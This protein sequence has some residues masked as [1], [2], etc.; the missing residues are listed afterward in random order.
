MS[1]IRVAARYAKAL[2]LEATKDGRLEKL[3]EDIDDF[4]K[5]C[6]NSRPLM[7][8]LSNPIIAPERKAVV[9]EEMFHGKLGDKLINAFKVICKK[10]REPYLYAIAQSVVH[11][12][13]R[14]KDIQEA[15]VIT[16][17]EISPRIKA[18]VIRIVTESTNKRVSLKESVDKNIIGGYILKIG[19]KRLDNS[20]KSQLNK[21]KNSF[22]NN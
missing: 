19:D 4:I 11:E 18:E 8:F 10:N 14:L 2:V 1:D 12:Y 21:L 20:L 6:D 22:A 17:I 3:K 9:L 16:A 15:E 7:V 5:S 13:N